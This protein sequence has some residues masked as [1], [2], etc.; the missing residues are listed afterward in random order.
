MVKR[1]LISSLCL[2]VLSLAIIVVQVKLA[3]NSRASE[4]VTQTDENNYVSKV[5]T[6]TK[7]ATALRAA[8]TRI[9]FDKTHE[10]AEI[11]EVG[12]DA[13]G[14][15]YIPDGL[16][17]VYWYKFGPSPGD[18]G[19]AI[20]AGHRDWGGELGL[21]QYLEKVKIGE[22]I[23]I[24]YGDKTAQKFVVKSRNSYSVSDVPKDTM[25][26][27]KGN[28]V[29]LISCTGSFDKDKDGYQSREVV[30][31]EQEK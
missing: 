25:N 14:R 22:K 17:D 29:T 24:E 7:N 13:D 16:Q 26:T 2:I 11:K 30:I 23:T 18:K 27:Q 21:F 31:L 15:M 28:K 20:I 8:P 1:I 3:E 19:N 9:I 4:E 12:T 10:S 6:P 5:T